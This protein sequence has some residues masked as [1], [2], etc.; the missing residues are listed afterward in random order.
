VAKLKEC[1]VFGLL[2]AKFAEETLV[3][4]GLLNP[5]FEQLLLDGVAHPDAEITAVFFGFSIPANMYCAVIYRWLVDQELAVAR[6]EHG[7]LRSLFG[8]VLDKGV[9]G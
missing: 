5:P 8:R 6:M 2:F 7:G 4:K 9:Q 3:A 1:C